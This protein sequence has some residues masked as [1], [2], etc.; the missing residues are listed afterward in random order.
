MD[1]KETKE[2]LAL[3]PALAKALDKVSEDGQLS[4]SD[5]GAVVGLYSTVKVAAQGATQVVA[6]L[7]D[8]DG[9]EAQELLSEAVAGVVALGAAVKNAYEKFSK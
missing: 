9:A 6:E 3:L 8:L 2:V 5:L 7:K 4:V 1:V